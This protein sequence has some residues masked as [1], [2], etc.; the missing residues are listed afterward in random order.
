MAMIGPRRDRDLLR[1]TLALYERS[2]RDERLFVRIRAALSDLAVLERHAPREGTILD[3]GCGHGLVANL[4][5]LGSPARRVRGIDIDP[6]KIEAARRTVRDRA[7]I[8]FDV[9]DALAL[10][11]GGDPGRDPQAEPAAA[12]A[13]GDP[14]A[15][16]DP[17]HRSGERAV[18]RQEA[19]T[20]DL[21]TA[22]GPYAAITVA[23]VFY[24]IPPDGQRRL[25][26]ACHRLLGAGG[27]FLWK[28][29]VRRPRW[30]YAITRGQEWLMTQLGPTQ[31]HGL[32]FLDT[33]ES[34]DA[35]RAAGFAAVARPLRSWRPYT[36]VLFIAARRG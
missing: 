4:L 10:A 28:S 9:A 12:P 36:D 14:A 3:L 19:A 1:R 7:N 8:R 17:S 24:L 22:G 5:A 32:H 2:P 35:L 18:G 13:E 6:K 23:D 27:L 33:D 25:L 16:S 29:Q 15:L 21:P 31:G 30:K 34:L 20:R 26:A 11:A